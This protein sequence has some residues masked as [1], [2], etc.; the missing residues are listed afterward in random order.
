MSKPHFTRLSV[1]LTRLKENGH[2]LDASIPTQTTS[3]V[4][5]RLVLSL[6]SQEIRHKL[7]QTG[8]CDLSL[9]GYSDASVENLV[10]FLYGEKIT[11]GPECAEIIQTLHLDWTFDKTTPI[12]LVSENTEEDANLDLKYLR[13]RSFATEVPLLLKAPRTLADVKIKIAIHIHR[14]HKVILSAMSKYFEVMFSSGMKEATDEIITL[15]G[16][17]NNVFKEVL[18]FIY[19][20]HI[21]V[22]RGNAQVILSTA[23][24]LQIAS[25][26]S[27]C[28]QFLLPTIDNTNCVDLWKFSETY[29][30]VLLQAGSW[31]YILDHFLEINRLKLI[32]QLQF[33]DIQKLIKDDNLYVNS[34]RDVLKF[35]LRWLKNNEGSESLEN[36]LMHVR[37]SELKTKEL[38]NLLHYKIVERN[39]QLCE[40]VKETIDKRKK[41]SMFSHHL[42]RKEKCLVVMKT[43]PWTRSIRVVCYSLSGKSW[44]QLDPSPSLLLDR[45]SAACSSKTNVYI[46]GGKC[47]FSYFYKFSVESNSW[48]V[49]AKM[50]ENRWY[51]AMG[52]INDVVY[53][54][55]GT[56]ENAGNKLRTD[57]LCSIAK[58][59]LK[60][61]Q[62]ITLNV[63]LNIPVF[64]SAYAS[65]KSKIFLIGGSNGEV[66]LK[67]IQCFD[68][69]LETCTTLHHQLPITLSLAAACTNNN[70]VFIVQRNG[71]IIHFNEETSPPKLFHGKQKY[72]LIGVTTAFNENTILVIS[73]YPSKD[74]TYAVRKFDVL[75]ENY[76]NVDE[77]K[78]PFDDYLYQSHRIPFFYCCH[79]CR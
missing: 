76:D 60:V 61:N 17:K 56:F 24:Y 51:H 41:R 74:E 50:N 45:G 54:L 42:T 14:C 43:C 9:V 33:N 29:N 26:Q 23:V 72:P 2:L 52:C 37:L 62:W 64:D 55:G 44:Y 75:C 27:L 1:Q 58:N 48:T 21:S 71:D 8:K 73:K 10:K 53:V 34:E 35:V 11:I 31:N 6:F 7:I 25:L 12:N 79:A 63:T 30:S 19:T 36:L 39:P 69:A 38:Q 46:T 70:D 22:N 3:V 20:G 5:H 4:L 15:Q 40:H 66:Y 67:D 77:T 68:S 78:L 49:L 18:N 32:R 65:I 59:D 13:N 28:E 47:T 16:I 57:P